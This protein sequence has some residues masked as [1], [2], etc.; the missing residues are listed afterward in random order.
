MFFT[1]NHF[2]FLDDESAKAACN[3]ANDIIRAQGVPVF[4]KQ[5]SDGSLDLFSSEQRP[6]DTHCG[7]II[8]IDEMGF[9]EDD[10]QVMT[11][12][13]DSQ[14]ITNALEMKILALEAELKQARKQ[15]AKN[16]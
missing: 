1:K 16:E 11:Q 9:F 8:G 14:D 6:K 5:F 13:P 3:K 12:T 7:I 15:G 4:G 2:G 10:R